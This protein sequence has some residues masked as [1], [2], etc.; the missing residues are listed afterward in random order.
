LARVAARRYVD[1][2]DLLAPRSAVRVVD[3]LPDNILYLGLIA[4]LW[5]NARVIICS[6]DLRDVAVSCRQTDFN[7]IRWANDWEHL[8]RRFADHR[9]IVAHWRET[10]PLPLLELRY[11][12]MV[13][14]LEGQARRLAWNF[15]RPSAW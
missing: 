4:M 14:D 11:E 2:L 7:V 13:D 5:P 9:R 8:A 15:I 12:D 10:R 3:K 6:R 1:R